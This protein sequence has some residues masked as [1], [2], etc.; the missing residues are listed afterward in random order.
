MAVFL[1]NTDDKIDCGN[2]TAFDMAAGDF[3]IYWRANMP[4]DT[5]DTGALSKRNGGGAGA[6]NGWTVSHFFDK[7]R[8]TLNDADGNEELITADN[9]FPY[10]DAIS[11]AWFV[12]VDRTGNLC[13]IYIDTTDATTSG[14]EDISALT[15]LISG[16]LVNLIMEFG[17]GTL[18]ECC[19][20]KGVALSTTEM[21]NIVNGKIKRLPLQIQPDSISGYW[22]F[23]DVPNGVSG[24]G[25]IYKDSSKNG[26]NGTG[27]GTIGKPEELLSLPHGAISV[28]RVSV[29]GAKTATPDVVVFTASVQSPTVSRTENKVVSVDVLSLTA[30]ILSPSIS[31]GTNA[32]IS[33]DVISATFGIQSPTVSLLDNVFIDADVLSGTFSVLSVTIALNSNVDISVD[34]VSGTFAVQVAS[35]S[36]PSSS[37]DSGI[38]I[39]MLLE[40]KIEKQ[41]TFNSLMDKMIVV[42]SQIEKLM[43]EES[44]VA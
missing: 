16:D 11:H 23:D 43:L 5:G 32:F 29:A 24:D 40:S 6:F 42:E 22:E 41:L 39:P 20:W 26:F 12:T 8:M 13:R 31:T 17:G 35:A 18:Q 4:A 30:N 9:A 1:D 15:G 25:A 36:K 3:T 21:A 37:L 44:R 14:D 28:T 7:W 34:V 10:D 38:E 27:T 19:I 33:V 2:Q